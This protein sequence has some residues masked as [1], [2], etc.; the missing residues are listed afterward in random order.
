MHCALPLCLVQLGMLLHEKDACPR[1]LY[2]VNIMLLTRVVGMLRELLEPSV[3]DG[4]ALFLGVVIT[5][6]EALA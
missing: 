5:H 6:L 1:F 4:D 3:G 2:K